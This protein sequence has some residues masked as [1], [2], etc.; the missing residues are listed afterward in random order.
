MLSSSLFNA[1]KPANV[2][3]GK[4]PIQDINFFNFDKKDSPAI[5]DKK[6]QNPMTISNL[7]GIKSLKKKKE[8]PD[9]D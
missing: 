8:E 5:Y 7:M 1:I 2:D 3:H 6:P 4:K 9:S